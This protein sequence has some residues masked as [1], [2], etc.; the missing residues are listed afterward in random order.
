MLDDDNLMDPGWLHAVAWAFDRWPATQVL[1]GARIVEDAPARNSEPSGSLPNL[2]WDAFDRRRLEQG[3]YID[4]NTIAMRSGLDGCRLTRTLHSSID[5]QLM[6]DLSAVRDVRRRRSPACTACAPNRICDIPER[7]E[8]NRRVRLGAPHPADARAVAQRHVPAAVGDLHPRGDVA[9][10]VNGAQIA[11]NSVQV[12]Q[13]PMGRPARVA[14]PRRGG[15]GVRSRRAGGVL[16]DPC[17]GELATFERWPPVR[18]AGALVR[19]RPRRDRGGTEPPAVRRRV[20]LSHHVP[21]LPGAHE[22]VPLFTSHESMRPTDRRD[23]VLSV[24][25][26][27]PSGTGPCCSRRWTD[28]P[29]QARAGGS[30]SAART[31]SRGARP[32]AAR[33]PNGRAA[34]VG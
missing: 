16:G 21:A 18:R 23:L 13:A 15:A 28:Q 19:L 3:N 26:G 30:C 34:F 29:A 11:F 27:C 22:L 25:A 7:L 12:P 6:L 24:S 20:G 31:A 5:W 1:Y 4:M 33:P 14:R 2:D 10:E 17:R 32:G 8:H 9:L